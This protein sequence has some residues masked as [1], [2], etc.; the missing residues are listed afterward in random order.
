MEKI[1][2]DKVEDNAAV[3]IWSE[4]TLW[5]FTRI[6]VDLVPTVEEYTTLLRCPR[7]QADKAYSRAANVQTFLKRLMSITGMSKQWVAKRADVFA[8]SI[9][10]LV[11]FPKVL[12]H[13][14]DAVSD[15]FDRLDKRVTSVPVEKVS[16]RVFSDK[17]SP[18]KDFV[19]TPMLDNIS[20]EKWMAIL[21]SLQDEDGAV[22]YALLLVL[23]QYRS[24]Q[25]IPVTQG[26][27]QCE[28]TYKGDNYKKKVHEISN[29]WNQTH[30]MKRFFVKLTTTPEYNWWWGK[31][32]NGNIFS[33]SQESTRPIEEQLQVILSKLDIVNQDFEKKS[34]E[35]GKMIEMLEDEKVQLGLDIDIQKLEA[36][37][38]YK[39]KNRAEEDLDNL[40]IDYKKL[41]LLIRTVG[42]GMAVRNP[43]RKD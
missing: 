15:L 30:K 37:K 26:L 34:S 12:G 38:M 23:R 13:I 27:A 19:A 18:L 21:H 5:D 25:F 10:G 31:R 17:H 42:L 14:D 24:R 35:L 43:R 11:I 36:E 3:R 6:S 41:C 22:G 2:L 33:T 39:G 9:Y 20:E 16:Y 1:F 40:K 28:F 8:L 29:A 32:V 7:I 4:K